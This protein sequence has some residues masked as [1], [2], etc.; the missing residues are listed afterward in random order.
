MNFVLCCIAVK[1]LGMSLDLLL[2]FVEWVQSSLY[3]M[4][5]PLLIGG[6]SEDSS[7]I[8]YAHEVFVPLAVGTTN[9]PASVSSRQWFF[10][11]WFYLL[12]LW[13]FIPGMCKLILNQRFLGTPSRDLWSALAVEIPPLY[14]ALQNLEPEVFSDTS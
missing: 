2:V 10:F 8:L 4:I 7:W 6:S 1:L 11:W 3:L 12:V 14:S 13:P 9:F 5:S